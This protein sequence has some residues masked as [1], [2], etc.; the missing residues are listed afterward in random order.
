M[1]KAIEAL[2]AFVGASPNAPQAPDAFIKLGW[3]NIRMSEVQ[4]QPPE[5]A[6]ALAAARSSYEQLMQRFPNHA[7]QPQGVFERARVIAM[8]GDVNGAMNELRRFTADQRL[9]DAPVAPMACLRLSAL[10]RSQNRAPEAADVLDKCRQAHEAK[11]TAD[12]ARA[13]WV[14]L[15]QYHHGLALKEA[16]K[17]PEA[18]AVLDIVVKAH[19][20]RP[21]GIEAGLRFG[22]ALKDEGLQKVT[23]AQQL[24]KQPGRNPQQQAE[25]RKK[26]DEG[27]QLLRQA[28]TYLE[29]RAEALKQP[30]PDA[31]ARARM[32]YDAAW[33]ARALADK[34]VEDARDKL[35]QD[36]W[37]KMKDEVAK[38]TA[39]GQQPPVV[40]MPE[41]PLSAVPLQEGEKKVRA[42]YQAL[43][44]A[45]PDLESNVDARFELAELL[46]EREEHDAAIKLL[47]E[48]L[49]KEPPP[50][51]TEKV[52]LR[53]GVCL[54]AKGDTK[55]A[56]EQ[57]QPLAKNEK[58]PL[59]AQA[60][61]RIGEVYMQ[62]KDY[63]AA[64][65]ELKQFRDF[66]PFQNV[67]GITD[68]AL[69]RLGHALGQLKQW[70]PSRQ[71]HEQVVGRFPGSP[72]VHEARYGI[73][74]AHQNKGE[75]DQ[76]VNVYTQVTTGT[77]T[78]LGARAQL[79]IGLCRLA[80]KRFPEAT[81]ALLIVP[82][83]YDYPELSSIALLEAARA[84]AEDRQRDKAIQVL[85]RL[86]RDH[87]DSES[88]RAARE[89]LEELKKG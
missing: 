68:R 54:A 72:W 65:K 40:A 71:A 19:P 69:L 53:L 30:K 23:A 85:Q 58:S 3:C 17:L 21:E 31:P 12:P 9:K 32:L 73:A 86:L 81:T 36:K 22:Q 10:L 15:V 76:A 39:P 87:P 67:P 26:L 48:A 78:E 74:W 20:T 24:L 7:L 56:I 41:V 33:A 34:E 77:A 29:G 80:Q 83:T 88:A 59:R 38:K 50:E 28:V 46:T 52:R 6:K 18:R 63:A 44:G 60:V 37:Q 84:L 27:F 55:A 79:N 51:M 66:G 57:L 47:K 89:R 42:I 5:K 64:E 43:I 49:D 1:S 11:M 45:F 16:G 8:Q 62:A 82:F 35:V 61:Y 2:N 70:D 75:F 14:P 25:D 4:A 13:L